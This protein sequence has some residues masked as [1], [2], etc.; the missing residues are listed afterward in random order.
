MKK[1]IFLS[2]LL[3]LAWCMFA[4]TFYKTI[5]MMLIVAVWHKTLRDKLPPSAKRWGMKAVWLCLVLVLWTAMPR[6][7]IHSGDRVR[8]VYL[9][10][11]DTGFIAK[12]PPL[13]QYV[14]NTLLPEEEIVNVGIMAARLKCL[15]FLSG[16]LSQELDH[17]IAAGKRGNFFSPFDNLGWENPMSGVYAQAFN[18]VLGGHDRAAY[19]IAPKHYDKDKAYP[20][21][22]FC[23][24]YLGNWQL[25]QG[26]WKD[27]D[28]C[29]V[30]SICTRGL[31]GIFTQED[32]GY[33]FSHYIPYLEQEGYRIDRDRRHLI[34]LSNGGSAII[35]TMNSQYAKQFKSI[36][37]ISCNLEGL[38][39]VPCRVNLIGGGRDAS[40]NRMPA[41]C[42]QLKSMGVDARLF[43]DEDETHYVLVNRR[44][45]II[46]FL[47]ND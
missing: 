46:E 3:L 10:E 42:R 39:R 38:R 11:D 29:I 44:K 12:H 6:Y 40:S 14:L 45:D 34:G 28:N 22:V 16:R 26:I 23:H 21:V 1:K 19:I 32:I 30:L 47:Q 7:R 17:D 4:T 27:L 5:C 37:T 20:L 43:Y 13:A 35:A 8:L 33:I 18:D 31:S 24:G 2:A 41:Q 9:K 15:P 25:Y 36:T